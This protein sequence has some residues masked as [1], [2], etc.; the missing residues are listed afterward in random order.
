M[1]EIEKQGIFASLICDHPCEHISYALQLAERRGEGRA[2]VVRV[3]RWW[4]KHPEEIRSLQSPIPG[5]SLADLGRFL[6]EKKEEREQEERKAAEK[7]R[8]RLAAW[9]DRM[10]ALSRGANT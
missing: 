5:Y 3:L 7:F 10:I 9:T 4:K 2:W 8:G 1:T 6:A